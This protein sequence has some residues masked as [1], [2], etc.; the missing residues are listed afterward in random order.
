MAFFNSQALALAPFSPSKLSTLDRCGLQ[1][2]YKYV[3]KIKRDK[4]PEELQVEVDESAAQLGTAL[5]RTSELMHEGHDLAAAVEKSIEE[6]EVP[7]EVAVEVDMYK[8]SVASFQSRLSAFK[9]GFSISTEHREIELAIDK[10]LNPCSYWDKKA[11]MRGKSDCILISDDGKSAV[12]I[13]LK[14]SKRATLSYAQDQLDF[15]SLMVFSNFPEVQQVKNGLFFLKH[16]KM[17]WSKQLL[18]RSTWNGAELISK[19]NTLSEEFLG[20]QEPDIKTSPLCNYCIY[21]G[22]CGKEK[23]IRADR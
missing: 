17:M 8:N 6:G 4:I 20:S 19:I 13:D 12:V 9:E 5:H 1:M 23:L 16:G 7:E 2:H 22:L 21:R 10:D 11:V 18:K 15:Y 14:S 3:Q